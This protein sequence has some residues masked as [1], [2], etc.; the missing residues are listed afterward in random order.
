MISLA[1]A[2]Y[3]PALRRLDRSLDRMGFAGSRKYW[4]PG[5]YPAGCPDHL[6]VPFAFKPY[7]FAAAEAEGLRCVLWL[8]STC[9]PIRP[10]DE[11]FDRI[12]GRG[13]V[14]FRT[15][16]QMVGE[17]ASD[18]ALAALRLDRESA[19]E[20]PEVNAAAIGL[21]L[22]HPVAAEFLARWRGAADDVT[23]FRGTEDPIRSADD[24]VAVKWNHGARCSADPRVK[25]HRYDQTVAGILAHQLG[26]ELSSFG[27]QPY[28]VDRRPIRPVDPDSQLPPPR[29]TVRPRNCRRRPRGRLDGRET[30]N[31]VQKGVG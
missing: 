29:Q 1:T 6:D 31:S 21:D 15:S 30:R 26:M 18:A 25:G 5:A 8:D 12:A 2:E 4:E 10:L 9:V 13:Y 14:V 19:M 16:T 23:P 11:V 24:Y 20:L 17:W 7:G 22:A 27:L 3:E 28:R